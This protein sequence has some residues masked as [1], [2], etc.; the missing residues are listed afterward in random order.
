MRAPR[1]WS[2]VTR[3]Q[4]S[5]EAEG[6]GCAVL[7]CLCALHRSLDPS[8]WQIA[9]RGRVMSIDTGHRADRFELLNDN[10]VAKGPVGVS[11]RTSRSAAEPVPVAVLVAVHRGPNKASAVRLRRSGRFWTCLNY[12]G[13]DS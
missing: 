10:E 2:E 11:L 8:P 6:L 5:D 1:R 12:F 3:S 7:G 4:I 9:G 13:S